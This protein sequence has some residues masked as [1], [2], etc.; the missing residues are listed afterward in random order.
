MSEVFGRKAAAAPRVEAEPATVAMGSGPALLF[1]GYDSFTSSARLTAVQGVRV[2]GGDV[3]RRDY[4]VCR[5]IFSLRAALGIS[6]SVAATF[7]F[8]SVSA[9]ADFM[10]GLEV[11]PHAVCVVVY[12]SA[13]TESVACR[14]AGL[15]GRVPENVAA[16]VEVNG[17]AWVSRMVTGAEYIA[18]YAFHAQSPK[19]AQGVVNILAANGIWEGGGLE[20]GLQ[21]ALELSCSQMRVRHVMRQ[22]MS[23]HFAQLLPEAGD[24]VRFAQGF[25]E[26]K[27][28]MPA[29]LSFETTGYEML[30]GLG[31][32]FAPVVRTRNLFTGGPAGRGLAQ[33]YAQAC[34]V[35]HAAAQIR[36]VYRAYL[37]VGDHGLE[38][39]MA[40][41]RADI[42]ALTALFRQM[43]A[44]PAAAHAR[45]VLQA[46]GLGAPALS[47]VVNRVRL[48]GGGGGEA[49][50]DMA[51]VDVVQGRRLTGVNLGGDG[52]LRR[53]SASYDGP[54]GSVTRQHGGEAP[55]GAKALVLGPQEMVNYVSGNFGEAVQRVK[56]MTNKGNS[57]SWPA[58]AADGA[59]GS[60]N[61]SA[62][63]GAVFLGFCG[64]AG[65]Q[66]D[67]LGV[68]TLT[69]GPA[70][71]G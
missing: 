9:K 10:R 31:E 20:S 41:V 47:F 50:E 42:A 39:R 18:V 30:P 62:G 1:Q 24:V 46:A 35:G 29:V 2:P 6:A 8:G 60:F 52:R 23:G 4:V 64:R 17:D 22:F 13:I 26:A 15:I 54:G 43:A 3:A 69:L 48:G 57:V 5:D 7:G 59:V 51:A 25:G 12:A 33:D 53:L 44:K 36:E 21:A 68:V 58:A 67:Q 37:Y 65:A 45:P 63:G 34:A 66:L 55:A 32:A 28:D 19:Q 71:W 49:F 70:V 40:V 27:P 56:V 38:A 61:W 14:E 11:G 16:F